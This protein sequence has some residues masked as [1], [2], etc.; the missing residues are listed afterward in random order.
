MAINNLFN[1]NID[2]TTISPN[3]NTADLDALYHDEVDTG[4]TPFR[5]PEGA[6]VKGTDYKRYGSF[7]TDSEV[8][9]YFNHIVNE[10]FKSSGYGGSEN[11]IQ[12]FLTRL[13]RFGTTLVPLNAMNYGFTFI[14]RPRL[15]MTSVNLLQWP[16]M[17]SLRT[18]QPDTVSFMIRGLLDTKMSRGKPTFEGMPKASIDRETQLFAEAALKS[19]LLDVYNP[20]FVP[21]CNS[22]KGISGFPDF[23]LTEETSEGDFYSTDFTYIKGGDFNSK[24]IEMTLEFRD[25][26]G[27]IVL[28]L[29]YY[30]TTIIALQAQGILMAYPDDI[31]EQRLNYTVSIYRFVTDPSRHVVLWWAKATG[32][33]PKSVPV[34][35]IFNVSQDE[36]MIT[37]A[38]NFSIP[39]IVNDVKYND[40]GI[41]M[42]FNTLVERYAGKVITFP[43][44]TNMTNK[45]TK[46]QQLDPSDLTTNFQGL[47]YINTHGNLGVCLEWYTSDIYRDQL[48]QGSGSMSNLELMEIEE[49]LQAS[50]A[51]STYASYANKWKTRSGSTATAANRA[52]VSSDTRFSRSS[53]IRN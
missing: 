18:L 20:F 53:S 52:T 3:I 49:K 45:N 30:W 2:A 4:R 28:A 9:S 39:F 40:P 21:L 33:F 22:L 51:R 16:A 46:Y 43:N 23:T 17:T 32:C 11:V 29:F 6:N 36:K 44:Y 24:T 13:D 7:L 26:Q 25:I 1:D 35:A 41:L 38:Q 31:Y 42:D 34:G 37:A 10:A 50:R 14:T 8:Q 15:N 5:G 12:N 47:P 19:G 27:S 48:S